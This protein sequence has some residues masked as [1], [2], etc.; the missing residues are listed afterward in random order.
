MARVFNAPIIAND[1]SL[2]RLLGA[3]VPVVLFFWHDHRALDEVNKVLIDL[4]MQEAGELIIAKINAQENPEG[5][6]LFNVNETPLLIGV[7]RGKEVTRATV[8]EQAVIKAH[9]SYL[10]GR[11][12][13]PGD[14]LTD[15]RD[16]AGAMP[17]STSMHPIHVTD[18]TFEQVVLASDLPVLVDFWAPWCGPCRVIAPALDGIALD[19]A[20]RLRVAKVNVDQ[21]P[22]YAGVYGVQGIPTLL[23]IK[24]GQV[25]DRIVGAMPAPQL[26]A[27]IAQHLK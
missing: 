3:P 9:V 1:Q 17:R 18:A 23:L 20:G 19:Y 5:R 24:H 21:N 8:R 14:D 26:R 13:R 16:V 11:A 22:H 10:L 27:R 6:R 12:P 4:A 7:H 25:I 2:S 15:H